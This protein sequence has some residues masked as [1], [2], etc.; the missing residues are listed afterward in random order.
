[1][2]SNVTVTVYCSTQRFSVL[3]YKTALANL[4]AKAPLKKGKKKTKKIKWSVTV[5]DIL[6]IL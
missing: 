4:G 3:M 2:T 5:V 1:M 6:G